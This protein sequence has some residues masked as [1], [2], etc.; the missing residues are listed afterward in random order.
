MSVEDA[1]NELVM[2]N[3][4]M[5]D[6]PDSGWKLRIERNKWGLHVDLHWGDKVTPTHSLTLEG[7]NLELALKIMNVTIHPPEV[8]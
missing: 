6:F 1:S 2:F 7:A 8:K 5:I 4:F 3:G